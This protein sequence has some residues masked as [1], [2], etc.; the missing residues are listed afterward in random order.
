M[1]GGGLLFDSL[2]LTGGGKL[3][4]GLGARGGGE[5]EG[6]RE[7]PHVGHIDGL[8]RGHYTS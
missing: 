2:A 3:L 7:A 4:G 5:Q 6:E 8:G 1:E